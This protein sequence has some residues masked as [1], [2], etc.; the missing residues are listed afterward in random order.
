MT[1]GGGFGG[2]D[3]RDIGG[4]SF[5]VVLGDGDGVRVGG[6]GEEHWYQ[7]R[8]YLITPEERFITSDHHIRSA[9]VEG[10]GSSG[11]KSLHY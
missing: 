11:C 6:G 3:L 4:G 10:S 1:A 9:C 2:G 7:M 8:R 5:P